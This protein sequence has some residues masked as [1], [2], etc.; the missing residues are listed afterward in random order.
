MTEHRNMDRSSDY[1]DEPR[2][3]RSGTCGPRE[4]GAPITDTLLQLWPLK[5]PFQSVSAG[6]CHIIRAGGFRN[7]QTS[8][9]A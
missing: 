5:Q 1:G 8:S 4:L 9:T 3:Q 6:I 7:Q 2:M